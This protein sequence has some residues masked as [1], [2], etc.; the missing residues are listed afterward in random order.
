MDKDNIDIYLY[1]TPHINI[2]IN[3]YLSILSFNL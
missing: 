2:I 1:T 3:F